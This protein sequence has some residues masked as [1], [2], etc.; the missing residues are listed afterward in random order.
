MRFRRASGI[1]TGECSVHFRGSRKTGELDFDAAGPVVEEHDRSNENSSRLSRHHESI[2]DTN[3]SKYS[4]LSVAAISGDL[5][6][7][8][9]GGK[10]PYRSS[11]QGEYEW[12]CPKH[13][14]RLT[15]VSPREVLL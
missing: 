15:G 12:K 7:T 9:L 5:H 6:V 3:Q 4:L 8:C 2:L 14:I 11:C 10:N 1:E 13:P